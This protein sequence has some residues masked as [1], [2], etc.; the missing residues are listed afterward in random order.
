LQQKI[1]AEKCEVQLK[2]IISDNASKE[3][4]ADI[5]KTLDDAAMNVTDVISELAV[6]IRV[7]MLNYTRTDNSTTC[8]RSFLPEAAIRDK[9]LL[10]QHCKFPVAPL[11]I[12]SDANAKN[13]LNT[14]F[15]IS[16]IQQIYVHYLGV[17]STMKSGKTPH[18]LWNLLDVYRV[19]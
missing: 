15:S 18:P 6:I 11:A 2:Q 5:L 9:T 4:I 17:H 12:Q 7:A 10:D 19:L 1:G 8:I 13:D 16:H 14:V 3:D